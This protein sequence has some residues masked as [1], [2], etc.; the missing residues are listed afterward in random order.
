MVSLLHGL[1]RVYCFILNLL[2]GKIVGA[3]ALILSPDGERVLLVYHTYCPNWFLPGGGVKRNEHPMEAVKRE[4]FEEAG[5][6]CLEDP[7]FL[8][9]Y[10]QKYLGVDDYTI[11]YVVRK[12]TQEQAHSGEIK[13]VTWFPITALPKDMDPGSLRRIQE[14]CFK[15]SKVSH[16]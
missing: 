16:W 14:Y 7:E 10:H 5:I 8:G 4:I 2:G 13:E 9:V 6:Q 11:A 15:A 12:F 1:F 3:R